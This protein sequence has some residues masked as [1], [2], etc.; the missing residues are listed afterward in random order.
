VAKITAD[1]A[2]MA[3]LLDPGF[4]VD[5]SE[6]LDSP[7]TLVGTIGE[8]TERLEQRR[9]RWGFSYHVVQYEAAAVDMAPLVAELAGR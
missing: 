6:V 9:E 5:S 4:G 3:E 2:S 1:S 8:I 7:M